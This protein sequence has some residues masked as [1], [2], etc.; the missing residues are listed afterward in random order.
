MGSL[1]VKIDG[2]YKAILFTDI[3]YLQAFKNYVR[4]H[5][6]TK[7]FTIHCTL[8]QIEEHLPTQSFCKIHK[9]YIISIDKISE[10]DH[11][12][13]TLNTIELPMTSQFAIDLK[14]KLAIVRQIRKPKAK[15]DSD[16][17]VFFKM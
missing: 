4:I 6:Y 13:V 12:S 11:E 16:E 10:F 17:S 7:I 5:T 1:F 3:C 15:L 9:S 8:K 14:H 2:K